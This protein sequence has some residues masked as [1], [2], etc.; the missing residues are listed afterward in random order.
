MSQPLVSS[1][2]L[3]L[4]HDKVSS[5]AVPAPII[6]QEGRGLNRQDEKKKKKHHVSEPG[7]LVIQNAEPSDAG[8]CHVG[9][10]SSSG[11]DLSPFHD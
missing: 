8:Q 1:F 2:S 7:A 6:S 5:E 10:S 9:G 11:S 4:S 3:S